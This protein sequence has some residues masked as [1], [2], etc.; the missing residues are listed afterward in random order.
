MEVKAGPSQE[1]EMEDLFIKKPGW[2]RNLIPSKSRALFFWLI[3]S[4]EFIKTPSNISSE[5]VPL[6]ETSKED[7]MSQF[8]HNKDVF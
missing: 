8:I 3:H 1:D 2:R 7:F 5:C 4:N 6:M